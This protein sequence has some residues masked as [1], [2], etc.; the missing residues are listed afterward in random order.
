MV[1][2]APLLRPLL[3]AALLVGALACPGAGCGGAD[4]LGAAADNLLLVTFDTTRADRVGAYGHA[5]ASTPHLDRLAAEGVLFEQCMAVGPVTL[6]THASILTGLYP[7]RHGARHNGTHRLPE[8]LPTLATALQDRGFDTGAVVSALVLDSRYGLDRGFD[9]YDDDLAAGDLA[10]VGMLRETDAADTTARALRWLEQP[11]EGRWFLWV[12]YFD[13][14]SSY[15]AP[16]AFRDRCP[17]DP[18]DAEIA[19]ADDGL[20]RL[21][22]ALEAR[23]ELD[24]TLVVAVADHGESLGEHGESTHG[25]FLHDATTRVPLLMR[26]PALPA[27]ARVG[28]VVSQVDL[29]PTAAELLGVEAP[30]GLDGRSLVAEAL[31]GGDARRPAVYQE[32]TSP[33]FQHGWAELRALRGPERRFISAPREELYELASDPGEDRNLLPEA[34]DAAAPLRRQLEAL[35]AAGVRDSRRLEDS[36]GGDEHADLAE[37]GYVFTDGGETGEGPRPDPK[38]KVEAWRL[39][40]RAFRLTGEKDWAGAE[41]V[42]RELIAA[43]PESIIIRRSMATTLSALGRPREAMTELRH[44]LALPG[45]GA[46]ILL[47]LAVLERQLGEPA[48]RKRIT[49]A[50]QLEPRDPTSWARL[51]DWQAEDGEPAEARAS[52]ERAIAL[53]QAFAPAWRGL[54]QLRLRAG[55]L[56]GAEEALAAA[57]AADPQAFDAWLAYARAAELADTPELAVERY[58][59][60]E[61]ARPGTA[62]VEVRLG[63]LAFAA[64]RLDD[65]ERHYRAALIR[66]AG[67]F[68]ARFN[69]ATLLLE[70]GAFGEAAEHLAVAC[71]RRPRELPALLAAAAAHQLAGEGPA[72]AGYLERAR[73]VD[74]EA[75]A[76]AVAGDPV[77]GAIR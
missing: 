19:Y 2:R 63:N 71:E 43:E 36:P 73:A 34:E 21:L 52:Y 29:F 53:D 59:A 35:L 18:Y 44:C 47:D 37:L 48:W 14:H 76:A 17:D 6:P 49:L 56:P 70:R 54:G 32:S 64:E 20:G 77:L 61:R 16:A 75:T 3:G 27:G 31:G 46:E 22:A 1:R 40:Q 33:Y 74:A 38:D 25:L 12:H 66:R 57:V 68:E 10:M 11:R 15:E 28:G 67:H 24:R 72:A 45:L 30:A 9:R 39:I 60:A 58:Q 41:S 5:G 26:H 51:G 13:P 42:L 50:Q 8:D 7:I 23:G 4:A 62:L 69:L 65:A 55:D